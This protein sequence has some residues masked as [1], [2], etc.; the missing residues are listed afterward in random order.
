MA[1]TTTQRK[2]RT[3]KTKAS[4][5]EDANAT[6]AN[7]SDVFTS[8]VMKGVVLLLIVA[9][10]VVVL[11]NSFIKSAPANGFT[12]DLELDALLYGIAISML[13]VI[14][15]FQEERWD[16][17]LCPGAVT[18]YLDAFILIL[19]MKWFEWLI[20]GWWSSWLMNVL[21]SLLPVMGLFIVI[22]ML[23]SKK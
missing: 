12:G 11:R 1:T 20:G 17:L 13:M 4:K 10:N 14:V 15:L 18:L 23:K 6:P 16:K 2:T 8:S 9:F 5:I 19:Y 3:R 21:L 7:L 22:I